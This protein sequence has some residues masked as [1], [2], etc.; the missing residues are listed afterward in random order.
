VFFDVLDRALKLCTV[1]EIML[2]G[3]KA[4]YLVLP[5]SNVW[6]GHILGYALELYTLREWSV[7]PNTVCRLH[8][9]W[10]SRMCLSGSGRAPSGTSYS[11]AAPL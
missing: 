9:A 5:W 11:D 8:C 4:I 3:G 2:P 1:Q 6:S 10:L 7:Y